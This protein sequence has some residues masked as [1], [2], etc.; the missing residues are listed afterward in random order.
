MILL[1]DVVFFFYTW[2][3]YA[4]L[5][6]SWTAICTIILMALTFIVPVFA[7]RWIPRLWAKPSYWFS[8]SRLKINGKENINPGQSYIM[9]ANHVSQFDIFLIYGWTPLD[10]KWVMKKEMRKV[11][12][13]GIACATMG[14]IFIDRR[15]RDAAIKTLENFKSRMR[16]GES[17][18]FFP[19]GTRG[20]GGQ[21]LDFKKGAFV[22]AKDLDLPI[23]PITIV[24]TENILPTGTAKLRSGKSIIM[25]HQPISVDDVRSLSAVELAD[26]AKQVIGQ[27]ICEGV[28]A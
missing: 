20:N 16:P 8:F 7:S 28:T 12:F 17:V 27:P 24:G 3:F 18:M 22:M 13:I 10:I 25:F 11:P 26:K 2:L 6:F 23:L 4:P 14:H 15:N 1:M 9:V 19:E 21:L 5:F